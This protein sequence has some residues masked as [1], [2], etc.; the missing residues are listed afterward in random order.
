MALLSL[1]AYACKFAR[2]ATILRGRRRSML[3]TC[4]PPNYRRHRPPSPPAAATSTSHH[5]AASPQARPRGASQRQLRYTRVTSRCIRPASRVYT[6]AQGVRWARMSWLLRATRCV[7]ETHRSR[8][9]RC[10]LHL[11]TTLRYPLLYPS[12]HPALALSLSL[13]L[14]LS[15]SLSLSLCLSPPLPLPPF[16]IG[17]RSCF[18]NSAY[19]ATLGWP[20]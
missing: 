5:P 19:S 3:I 10:H 16:S 8:P 4:L 12:H 15:L 18:P 7:R 6:E 1:R 17:M 9:S 14:S 2:G 11:P 20:W 13:F